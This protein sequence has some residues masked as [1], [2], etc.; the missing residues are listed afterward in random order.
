MY[1]A[2]TSD[3]FEQT[4]SGLLENFLILSFKKSRTNVSIPYDIPLCISSEYS[5]KMPLDNADIDS[6][7][8]SDTKP[9]NVNPSTS[10]AE[11]S[12]WVISTELMDD[13][14]HGNISSK[15]NRF[16]SWIC[17][18]FD[19][20][21]S[22]NNEKS[23]ST[24]FSAKDIAID[25]SLTLSAA[26]FS[27]KVFPSESFKK[28]FKSISSL[29]TT[30]WDRIVCEAIGSKISNTLTVSNPLNVT[31]FGKKDELV[32]FMVEIEYDPSESSIFDRSQLLTPISS[33][34]KS[35]LTP[36]LLMTFSAWF[37]K[38]PVEELPRSV[39]SI[40]VIMSDEISKLVCAN[41]GSLILKEGRL[42]EATAD[43]T[44]INIAVAKTILSSDCFLTASNTEYSVAHWVRFWLYAALCG[45]LFPASWRILDMMT[46]E[47]SPV[48]R[49]LAT[50]GIWIMSS[51]VVPTVSIIESKLGSSCIPIVLHDLHSMVRIKSS[52]EASKAAM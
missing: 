36:K 29:C 49:S 23:I 48:T 50:C 52:T 6:L 9:S 44:C 32:I 41:K 33:P 13:R 51:F 18:S 34:F 38:K 16:S 24:S 26:A 35:S 28:K 19:S 25:S 7:R 40:G 4:L 37:A 12:N 27:L 30:T 11:N 39:K 2:T 45:H 14:T 17:P 31:D 10:D 20:S 43:P 1:S 21:A 8:L 5:S 15:F 3:G 42:N 47:S 22:A 46:L